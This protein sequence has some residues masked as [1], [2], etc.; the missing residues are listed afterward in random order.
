[1]KITITNFNKTY[2]VETD[3]DMDAESMA[4]AFKSLLVS[5]GYHPCN[6]DE[7]FNTEYKWFTQEEIDENRQGHTKY[8]YTDPDHP[9]YLAQEEDFM[10][11][12]NEGYTKGWAEAK[13]QDKVQKFQDDLYKQA[14]DMFN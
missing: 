12:Y 13:H 4:D 5:M 1:M 11:K 7:L 10:K 9:M 6:V 14:D 8:N 3:E 2:S